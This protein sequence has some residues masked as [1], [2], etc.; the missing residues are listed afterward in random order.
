MESNCHCFT[1]PYYLRASA[2]GRFFAAAAEYFLA[3][4]TDGETNATF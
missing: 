3:V 4:R 1:N 2:H